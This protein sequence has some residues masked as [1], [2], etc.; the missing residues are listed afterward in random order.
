MKG[1]GDNVNTCDG[2]NNLADIRRVRFARIGKNIFCG[3][4]FNFVRRNFNFQSY[5][6][7]YRRIGRR[8]IFGTAKNHAVRGKI[9]ID[10][11]NVADFGVGNFGTADLRRRKKHFARRKFCRI[12]K[13]FN[14]EQKNFTSHG[15]F[16]VDN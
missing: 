15:F 10:G 7:I 4:E 12:C 11:G 8:H 5:L 1:S 6:R 9:F 3:I 14:T 2:C 16:T 13:K